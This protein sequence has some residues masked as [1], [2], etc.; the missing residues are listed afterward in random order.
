MIAPA[1][2]I[3]HF[4]NTLLT[5]KETKPTLAGYFDCLK[6]LLVLAFFSI[7]I[8]SMMYDGV[9]DFNFMY[10][11]KPPQDNLPFLNNKEG[12]LVYITRYALLVLT[13][14]TLFYIKP[15]VLAV[16]GKIKKGGAKEEAKEEEKTEQTV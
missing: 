13:V 8:N 12:W 10:V 5:N 9:S 16:I 2:G 1:A 14:V 4:G 11:V 15:I 3:V 7:Y 6:L